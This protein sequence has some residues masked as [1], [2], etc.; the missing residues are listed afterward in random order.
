MVLERPCIVVQLKPGTMGAG[1]AQFA[2]SILNTAM[3]TLKNLMRIVD[4]IQDQI[5]NLSRKIDTLRKNP[6]DV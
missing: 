5:V 4:N 2:M 3:N 1:M 6:I